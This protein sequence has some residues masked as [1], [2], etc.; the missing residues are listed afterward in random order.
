MDPQQVPRWA[1]GDALAVVWPGGMALIDAT[2]GLGAAERIWS[3]LHRES[4]LGTFLKALA[5]SSDTGFLDLPT[6]AV[7]ILAAD[8]CHVAV[9]GPVP[10]EAQVAG[11]VESITGEGVTT[12]AEKV[13]PL[14][15]AI[16]LGDEA[17]PDDGGP[18]IDGVLPASGIA[19]GV[20][21]PAAVPSAPE[22]ADAAAPAEPEPASD[23]EPE[24]E[25]DAPPAPSGTQR[26]AEAPEVRD[27]DRT[28]SGY[29]V[30]Q[31]TIHDESEQVAPGPE[32]ASDNPYFS[33][34]DPSVALDI[35]AAA[36]RPEEAPSAGAHGNPDSGEDQALGDTVMEQGVVEVMMSAD[37]SSPATGPMVLARFCDRS[38]PNPPDRGVCFVCQAPVTGDARMTA[39]PQLGYVRVEGGE[40]VPL[41]GP[42]IAGRNPKS[43]VLNLSET[44]K[45]MALPHP[46]VSG[47]HLAFLL[48][49]WHVMVRDLN[50]SNG[51]Y[52]R[53]HG[54]PAVRLP[55]TEVPLV[56]GDLIDLGQGLF[57]HLE[58]TP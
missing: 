16:R 41:K 52:L 7:V 44:P 21:L 48:E 18:I 1:P 40:S 58:G 35:E 20:F 4:Q 33:L 22:E 55:D 47:T 50:S 19:C 30:V 24:A 25:A 56:P 45:L 38:H 53:R 42:I 8:R 57:I 34:W 39:R 12:W 27:P 2:V 10:V 28:R 37:A 36:I 43:T 51:T 17:G 26:A 13:M 5:E 46:H 49:G 54:Q 31:E 3:R 11:V 15:E 29:T 14:P 9:R 32:R 6:F 23:S